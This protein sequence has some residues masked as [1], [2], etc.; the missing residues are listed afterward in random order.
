[1]KVR[2][3]KV[4]DASREDRPEDPTFSDGS[5][6]VRDSDNPAMIVAVLTDDQFHDQFELEDVPPNPS[7]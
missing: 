5:W 3:K 1:M 7:P 2:S 6:V 4:Y